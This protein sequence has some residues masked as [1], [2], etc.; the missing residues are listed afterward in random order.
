ML[1]RCVF[2]PAFGWLVIHWYI[3][4]HNR[5]LTYRDCEALTCKV[6][7]ISQHFFLL[8]N[9]DKSDFEV[10]RSSDLRH[11]NLILPESENPGLSKRVCGALFTIPDDSPVASLSATKASKRG[12]V[13]SR[14]KPVLPTTEIPVTR[15][16]ITTSARPVVNRDMMRRV[17]K[18]ETRETSGWLCAAGGTFLAI[19]SGTHNCQ[20]VKNKS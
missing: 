18:R 9:V 4:S 19:L 11:R 2:Q 20:K 17:L 6:K 12:S 7:L 8:E 15:Q 13:E 14:L 10:L 5:F 16:T 3:L 1:R